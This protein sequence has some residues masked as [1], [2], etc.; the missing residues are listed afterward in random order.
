ML[1]VCL[2]IGVVNLVATG[3]LAWLLYRRMPWMLKNPMVMELTDEQQQTVTSIG[4]KEVK[5]WGAR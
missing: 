3:G 4:R 1:E 2:A 5:P